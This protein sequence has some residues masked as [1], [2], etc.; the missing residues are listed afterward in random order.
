MSRLD[1]YCSVDAFRQ[2]FEPLWEREQ[3]AQGR[4]RRRATRVCPS[5]IMMILIL[6][7]QPGFR[8][9]E[10]WVAYPGFTSAQEALTSPRSQPLGGGVLLLPNWR[11]ST[12][13]NVTRPALQV[14]SLGVSHALRAYT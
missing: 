3:V 8:S 9:V 4:R 2:A 13:R 12:F 10:A 5:E 11:R 7:Q 1:V 6:F 14:S